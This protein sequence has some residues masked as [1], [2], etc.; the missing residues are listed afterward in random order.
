MID[1]IIDDLY[2]SDSEISDA[3]INAKFKE[4]A[5]SPIIKKYSNRSVYN[6]I[7]NSKGLV[8]EMTANDFGD[9]H[10][11]PKG[12]IF[13]KDGKVAYINLNPNDY[14]YCSNISYDTFKKIVEGQDLAWYEMGFGD[15]SGAEHYV[16][17][18]SNDVDNIIS[19]CDLYDQA[20]VL[21]NAQEYNLL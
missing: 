17:D 11:D 2:F 6:Q 21:F 19:D 9:G 4:Y 18:F 12:Y 20:H 16:G 10:G 3:E 13:N 14:I 8:L 1:E 7:K 5:Q 15:F